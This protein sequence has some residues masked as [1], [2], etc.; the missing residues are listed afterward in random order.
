MYVQKYAYM[1]SLFYLCT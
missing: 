1:I